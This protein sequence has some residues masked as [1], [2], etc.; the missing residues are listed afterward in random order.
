MS[1]GARCHYCRKGHCECPEP[2]E[3]VDPKDALIA[4]MAEA[5]R[6]CLPQITETPEGDAWC[7]QCCRSAATADA[8]KHKA[9]CDYVTISTLLASDAARNALAEREE[10][11]AD[12]L[13]LEWL[14]AMHFTDR[15]QIDQQR[16]QG[17]PKP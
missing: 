5:L 2:A 7:H 1:D 4:K 15:Q 10:L 17:G 8:I 13:R 6:D 12:R 3:R 16:G 14:M 11:L 9:S